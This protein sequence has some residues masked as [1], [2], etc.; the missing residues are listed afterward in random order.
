MSTFNPCVCACSHCGMCSH[1][2]T[3]NGSLPATMVRERI[4]LRGSAQ[5][6]P[7]VCCAPLW[8]L[9]SL[10]HFAHICVVT[11][12]VLLIIC[13]L[14]LFLKQIIDLLYRI[15]GQLMF[16]LPLLLQIYWSS[17]FCVFRFYIES[18]SY[19]K[20]NATIELFFLNAKSIIYKVNALFCCH[21]SSW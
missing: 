14:L 4:G 3:N 6:Q 16:M 20:D 8:S 17:P 12:L 7:F 18:I 15:E 5:G 1:S 9:W 10:H 2:Q 21:A 13:V 11:F 19:L